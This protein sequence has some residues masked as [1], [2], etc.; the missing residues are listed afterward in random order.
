MQQGVKVLPVPMHTSNPKTHK[1]V[2]LYLCL[3]QE[4][5]FQG[6]TNITNGMLHSY[7]RNPSLVMQFN[8]L[9]MG[10][11]GV[12]S[13]Q[14]RPALHLT[15]VAAPTVGV[16]GQAGFVPAVEAVNQGDFAAVH[17]A[18]NIHTSMEP[19]LL[20]MSDQLNYL[21]LKEH[22][23]QHLSPFQVQLLVVKGADL[24]LTD[25]QRRI[26]QQHVAASRNANRLGGGRGGGYGGR[27]YGGFDGR[28]RGG[29]GGDGRGGGRGRGGW[30]GRGR[31]RG[32]KGAA[33]IDPT[34][35]LT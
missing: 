12:L 19:L 4:E 7:S 29:R 16:A 28:G 25:A 13:L 33:N 2:A 24:T 21:E 18:L 3:L 6:V 10:L 1:I 9:L 5:G 11:W 17:T 15:R 35:G 20:V 8:Q 34:T 27:G 32:A 26:A 23:N 22:E 30:D 31:G 14:L